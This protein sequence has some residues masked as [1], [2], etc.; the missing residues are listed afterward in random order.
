[1]KPD[2]GA[3][4][5]YMVGPVPASRRA[6]QQRPDH[7]TAPGL[8]AAERHVVRG[9]CRRRRGGDAAWPSIRPGRRIRSRAPSW[10]PRRPSRRRHKGR[11]ASAR[12]TSLRLAYLHKRRPPNPNAGLNQFVKAAADGTRCST[13][14][15]GRRRPSRT[16]RGT[17][18]RGRTP[19]GRMRPGRRRLERRGLGRCCLGVRCLGRRRLERRRLERRGVGGRGLGGQRRAIPRSAT[20]AMRPGDQDAALAA[21]GSSIRLRSERSRSATQ[22]DV[23]ISAPAVASGRSTLNRSERAPA[24]G[25]A[26]RCSHAARILRTGDALDRGSADN[27]DMALRPRIHVQSRMTR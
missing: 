22:H 20:P 14:P 1:M 15:P 18:L 24:T 12:S 21:S 19:P 2:I 25:P 4:G 10:S 6:P 7:V 17:R 23:G 27:L 3:P 8:H 9:T 11:S 16:R 26:F 13:R 5:R